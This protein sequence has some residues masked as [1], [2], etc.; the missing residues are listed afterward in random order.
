MERIEF[1]SKPQPQFK[2]LEANRLLNIAHVK[3]IMQ[4]MESN[5]WIQP[6]FVTK[7]NYVVD[8]NH[9]YRAFCNLYTTRP[10][11]KGFLRVYYIDSDE[12]PVKLA[13][14]LNAG[15]KKWT[16]KDYLHA[17]ICLNVITYIK[18]DQFLKKYTYMNIKS[19]IQLITGRYDEKAFKEG[20]LFIPSFEYE[21]AALMMTLL[22]R[23][24][25][26]IDSKL[27]CKRDAVLGFRD[28]Y[29]EMS[30]SS[31][32]EA[33]YSK[34]SQFRIPVK[35]TRTEWYKAYKELV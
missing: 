22:A 30:S 27:P 7:D 20:Y 31:E 5:E 28:I 25:A 15:H 2:F 19:A 18:L 16:A 33:F 17:Y 12:N 24:I 3:N 29:M 11:F 4:S 35:H 10:N 8:G 14:K 21:R 9:R 26:T 23:I 6:I 13:I 34:L 32:W 1:I